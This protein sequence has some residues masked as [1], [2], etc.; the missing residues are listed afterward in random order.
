MNAKTKLK[1]ERKLTKLDNM[2]NMPGW[3]LTILLGAFI[4]PSLVVTLPLMLLSVIS[5]KMSIAATERK[6]YKEVA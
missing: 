2:N 6:L 4:P 5:I 3:V 1:L